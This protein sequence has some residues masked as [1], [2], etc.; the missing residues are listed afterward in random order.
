MD[1]S[2]AKTLEKRELLVKVDNWE[3]PEY[4]PNKDFKWESL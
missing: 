2:S 3:A 4:P 1:I